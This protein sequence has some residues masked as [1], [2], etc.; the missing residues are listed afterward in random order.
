[1]I[2]RKAIEA[3]VVATQNHWH[4]RAAVDAMAAGKD[5]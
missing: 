2:D 1:V 5:V 4:A 3:A